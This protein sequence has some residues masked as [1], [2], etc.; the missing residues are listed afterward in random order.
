MRLWNHEVLID[1]EGVLTKLMEKITPPNH[2][3]AKGV[4]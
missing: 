4:E 3:F 2:P 1:V